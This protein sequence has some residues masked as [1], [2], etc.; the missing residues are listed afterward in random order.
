MRGA[1]GRGITIGMFNQAGDAEIQQLGL[2]GGIHQDVG[3]LQVAMDHQPLVRVFHCRADLE[4]QRQALAQWQRVILAPA[5][6]AV[7]LDI[8]HR[9]E[10]LAIGTDAAIQQVRDVGVLQHGQDAAFFGHARRQ[11]GALRLAA[12]EQL[13]CHRLPG[14]AIVAFGQIHH[15]HAAFADQPDDA[16]VPGAR[17][18]HLHAM[19]EHGRH[20]RE[21][22]P[23][24]IPGVAVG[25]RHQPLHLAEQGFV[26]AAAHGEPSVTR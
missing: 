8:F 23:G 5:I 6:D 26:A 11:A 20:Q 7:A 18:I 3:G 4:E 10:R 25:C 1:G 13:Q 21:A 15:A 22:G 12:V 16:V 9:D 19:L 14:I 24:L 17:G 2:A